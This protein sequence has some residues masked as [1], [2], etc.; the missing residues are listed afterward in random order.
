[1]LTWLL[2]VKKYWLTYFNYNDADEWMNGSKIPFNQLS[3][4][5][6]NYN[7]RVES[8]SSHSLG[9]ILKILNLIAGGHR[10]VK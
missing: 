5:I 1:M 8:Y 9:E 3:C 6:L 7:I 4:N 10:L 2:F